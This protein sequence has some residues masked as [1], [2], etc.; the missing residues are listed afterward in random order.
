[1]SL[2]AREFDIGPLIPTARGLV[3]L[4]SGLGTGGTKPT[5]RGL[6]YLLP[7]EK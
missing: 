5:T 1:L 4:I 6:A 2:K 7:E 3:L